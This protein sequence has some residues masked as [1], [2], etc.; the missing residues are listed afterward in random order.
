MSESRAAGGL[1]KSL[2]YKFTKAF[3]SVLRR[4]IHT[5]WLTLEETDSMHIPVSYSWRLN[6]RHYGSLQGLDKQETVNKFGKDQVMVWRRS[7]DV[8]PPPLTDLSSPHYPGNDP[9]YES[10]PPSSLPL[11]ES[12]ACTAKRFLPAWRDS[13]VPSIISGERVLLAAHGN[14]LR[15]LV[16]ILDDIPQD[17]ITALDIPTG[18]PLLY[19]LDEDLRPVRIEGNT[20]DGKGKGGISGMYLGDGVAKRIEA[21]KNQTK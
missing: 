4:A 6:E 14:T 16:M 8:P 13:I 19:H 1:L 15:S 17:E 10:V 2:G 20:D 12:L 11:S 5:T 7:Y 21:V 18:V 3:T 9:R